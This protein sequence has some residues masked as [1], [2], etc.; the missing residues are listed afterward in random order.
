MNFE[1]KYL[2]SRR[3]EINNFSPEEVDECF[4]V[5]RE[6]FTTEWLEQDG[7]NVLQN[8]WFRKDTLATRELFSLGYSIKQMLLFPDFIKEKI[9][10][11]K[12]ND[13]K[14]VNGAIFEIFALSFFI[15]HNI[16]PAKK[17]QAGYDGIINLGKSKKIKLSVKNY[18]I[19]KH[20]EAFLK[21]AKTVNYL[22]QK[23]LNDYDSTPIEIIINKK[24]SYPSL[25]DWNYLKE[26]FHGVFDEYKKNSKNLLRFSIGDWSVIVQNL[27]QKDKPFS[28]LKKSYTL[29]LSSPFHNNEEKNLFDKLEEAC[30]NIVKHG[31]G[32]NTDDKNVIIIHLPKV[33]SRESCQKWVKDF[34]ELHPNKPI[35]MVILYQPLVVSKENGKGTYISHGLSIVNRESFINDFQSVIPLHIE[36]PIG[37]QEYGFVEPVIF[38]RETNTTAFKVDMKNSYVFQQGQHFHDAEKEGDS[39]V[40]TIGKV[41]SGVF[42]QTIFDVLDHHIVIEGQFEPVDELSIM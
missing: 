1:Y 6:T 21:E 17:N 25:N 4:R 30:A 32:E 5:L 35:S 42:T 15:S 22:T 13:P 10:L 9:G 24:T 12:T 39:I 20:H 36:F 8:L 19:S 40:G 37:K 11:I 31:G 41:A 26:N 38:I 33:S 7:M 2:G 34:F 3:S 23:Y 28:S 16:I 14:N 18:S 27:L 29:I